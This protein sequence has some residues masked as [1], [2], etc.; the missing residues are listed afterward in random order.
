[1]YSIDFPKLV[2]GRSAE[3]F[4]K[5]ESTLEQRLGIINVNTDT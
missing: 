5:S 3:L 1:M 2:A 4:I